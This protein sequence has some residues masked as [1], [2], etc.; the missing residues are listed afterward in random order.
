M[1]W[2]VVVNVDGVDVLL[3]RL[4][5]EVTSLRLFWFLR[6]WFI[7]LLCLLTLEEVDAGLGLAYFSLLLL[8]TPLG[9]FIH[10]Q[11]Y[12]LDLLIDLLELFQLHRA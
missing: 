3:D 1:G 11:P 9:L 8:R 2:V 12:E 6:W 4:A 5:G 10:P 7:P